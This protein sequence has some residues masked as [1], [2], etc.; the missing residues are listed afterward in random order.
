MKSIENNGPSIS[1]IFEK[2]NPSFKEIFD[3][4][5]F[6]SISGCW[7]STGLAECSKQCGKFDKLNAQFERKEHV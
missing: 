2:K 4:N 5:F 6:S 1:K 7:T 3:S